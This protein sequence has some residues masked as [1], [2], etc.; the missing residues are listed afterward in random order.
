MRKAVSLGVLLVLGLTAVACGD[1]WISSS[2]PLKA[3]SLSTTTT[4]LALTTPALTIPAPTTS[5]RTTTAPTLP[6]AT[7]AGNALLLDLEQLKIAEQTANSSLTTMAGNPGAYRLS[8][9]SSTIAPVRR[10]LTV[11]VNQLTAVIPT[12]T[13]NALIMPVAQS[14]SSKLSS[15]LQGLSSEAAIV[16]IDAAQVPVLSPWAASAESALA[17]G[18]AIHGYPQA[19]GYIDETFADGLVADFVKVLSLV[20]TVPSGVA[21]SLSQSLDRLLR[22][23]SAA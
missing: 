15:D 16:Q 1:H 19:L 10:D 17:V 7:P 13:A 22:T 21:T 8:Q 3:S 18:E 5:A 4:T 23:L 9:V 14:L 20:V 2:A 6:P 11:A 12:L